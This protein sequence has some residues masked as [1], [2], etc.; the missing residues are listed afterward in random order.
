M[1]VCVCACVCVGVRIV[2]LLAYPYMAFI[3]IIVYP[4]Y[5]SL[6][7]D[8]LYI[9]IYIYIYRKLWITRKT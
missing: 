5:F 8:V 7:H 2:P 6:I 3:P 9:Y 1:C 4:S